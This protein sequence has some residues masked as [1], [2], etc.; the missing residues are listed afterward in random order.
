MSGRGT[1]TI[2]AENSHK[3][4]KRYKGTRQNRVQKCVLP[5]PAGV[6]LWLRIKTASIL[7]YN[8]LQG[9]VVP[10]WG[11][12][13]FLSGLESAASVVGMKV[14]R[15]TLLSLYFPVGYFLPMRDFRTLSKRCVFESL[16]SI[17]TKNNGNRGNYR[18]VCLCGVLPAFSRVWAKIPFTLPLVT[19]MLLPP[20]FEGN[21]GNVSWEIDRK[22]TRLNSSHRT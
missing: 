5:A 12:N 13:S 18:A 15:E 3:L 7:T 14:S 20:H 8:T 19:Q 2:R 11:K 17:W 1:E 4:K 16:F 21:R 9:A 22:S 10:F 6:S